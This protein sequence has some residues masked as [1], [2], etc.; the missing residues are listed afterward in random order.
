MSTPVP[1]A[2]SVVIRMG[3]CDNPILLTPRGIQRIWTLSFRVR[4]HTAV[5]RTDNTITQKTHR[6]N[7]Q[8]Q[9]VK[10]QSQRQNRKREVPYSVLLFTFLFLS[11]SN[12]HLPI[13]APLTFNLISQT[14]HF[15]TLCNQQPITTKMPAKLHVLIVG[16]GVSGLM[17]GALLER[18]GISYEVQWVP[19]NEATDLDVHLQMK[20]GSKSITNKKNKYILACMDCR[21]SKS[22]RT[23]KDL[24]PRWLWPPAW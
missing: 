20:L 4:P 9:R 18:A 5:D 2:G 19:R 7:N 22:Q 12:T 8:D 6:S 11:H 17:A 15:F 10:G 3:G 13:Q 23:S 1:A 16:A 21:F 14:R 24:D